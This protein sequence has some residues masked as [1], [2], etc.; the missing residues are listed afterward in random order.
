MRVRETKIRSRGDVAKRLK[1]LGKKMKPQSLKKEEE[2]S[3][4]LKK[5]TQKFEIITSTLTKIM[6]RTTLYNFYYSSRLNAL[7]E[8]PFL[9]DVIKLHE[10]EAR[11][12]FII[13]ESIKAQSYKKV[14]AAIDF[15]QN[16]LFKN[17]EIITGP[18]LLGIVTR[19]LERDGRTRDAA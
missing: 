8:Y 17:I 9:M 15:Y 10:V 12:E 5:S 6:G 3:M 14:Q 4:C 18:T 11:V 13:S 1:F 7:K 2:L 19:A 16:T